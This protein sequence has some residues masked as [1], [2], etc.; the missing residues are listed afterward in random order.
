MC[1]YKQIDERYNQI[2]FELLKDEVNKLIDTIDE[3]IV[4]SGYPEDIEY[5]ISQ[6]SLCEIVVRI[7]KRYAYY[8]YFHKGT[9]I[10]E[11]KQTALLVYWILKFKPISINDVRY[12]NERQ[13]SEVNEWFACY[14]ESVYEV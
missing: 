2:E 9:L 8:Q 13:E 1:V 5:R 6:H 3:F 7:D 14:V 4:A 12:R 11:K 10:N